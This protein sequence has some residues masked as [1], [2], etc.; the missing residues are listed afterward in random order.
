LVKYDKNHLKTFFI[1]LD[2]KRSRSMF[3]VHVIVHMFGIMAVFFGLVI[4]NIHTLTTSSWCSL[5]KPCEPYMYSSLNISMLVLGVVAMLMGTFHFIGLPCMISGRCSS[6]QN[7]IV[8][9]ENN[10]PNVQ[11][12]QLP[13]AQEYRPDKSY[14]ADP[15][16][17]EQVSR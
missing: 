2:C 5:F 7:A 1:S 8:N 16:S 10:A 11:I 17:Y 6:N 4:M 15:P 3:N 9:Y 14:S 13:A 12:V